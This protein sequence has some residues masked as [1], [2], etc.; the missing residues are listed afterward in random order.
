[1]AF[2]GSLTSVD[3][4]EVTFGVTVWFQGGEGPTVTLDSNGLAGTAITSG[5]GDV[6]LVVGQ[7]GRIKLRPRMMATS[8][9]VSLPLSRAVPVRVAPAIRAST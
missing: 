2:D 8:P 1:M 9:L 3:G 4:N 7:R 6:Q 5:A